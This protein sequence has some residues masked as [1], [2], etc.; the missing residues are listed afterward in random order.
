[1]KNPDYTSHI[2]K[3]DKYFA[4]CLQVIRRIRLGIQAWFTVTIKTFFY[5]ATIHCRTWITA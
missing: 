3:I 4:G 1:M 2:K 5:N